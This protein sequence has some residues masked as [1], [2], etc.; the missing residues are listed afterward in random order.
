MRRLL[1]STLS[2]LLFVAC[3]RHSGNE[4]IISPTTTTIFA[5]FETPNDTRIE[6]NE[7]L[8]TVWNA[9]DRVSV[10]DS[11]AE[12]IEGRYQGESGDR[13][14]A[15]VIPN[16]LTGEAVILYPYNSG[17]KFDA[18]KQYI[19]C[20]VPN[21]QTYKRGS[22][23]VDGNMMVAS[24]STTE[25]F[26][27][28]SLYGWLRVELTGEDR[29]VE[30]ISVHSGNNESMAGAAV[31]DAQSCSIAF[32]HNMTEPENGGSVGGLLLL[33]SVTLNCAEGVELSSTP[34]HFY[35]GLV[36]QSFEKGFS[37]QVK[38][39][40][41]ENTVLSHESAITIKRNHIYP[42]KERVVLPDPVLTLS[43]EA[44]LSFSAER[45]N[46][47]ISYTLENPREG[48][49]VVASSDA[50][51]V[52]SINTLVPKKVTFIVEANTT[53]AARSANITVKYGE[54]SFTVKVKQEAGKVE[55]PNVERPERD[56]NKSYAKEHTLDYLGGAVNGKN[57]TVIIANKAVTEDFSNPFNMPNDTIC[58]ILDIYSSKSNSATLP[59]GVYRFDK[60]DTGSAG[61][62]SA[63]YS[64]YRDW[65]AG[66][67]NANGNLGF[68]GGTVTV[69]E[70]GIYIDGEFSEYKNDTEHT[71][72]YYAI[73]EGDLTLDYEE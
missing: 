19:E 6:L 66:M 33:K 29:V 64:S 24:G 21:T 7:S 69:T 27:L 9:G 41:G 23:G 58:Y 47:V 55:E 52:T 22:Y 60:D 49:K 63:T 36:P 48:L 50:S 34:T 39:R 72:Y 54:Q 68:E 5:S 70:H 38:Y 11:S 18:D 4:E 43:S 17:Y 3:S 53:T 56:P 57:Y 35:I 10:F 14:G 1:L 65:G 13:G 37:V 30:S 26:L 62:F 2:I 59:T 45:G 16:A 15:I 44:E 25:D 8:K 51:W 40:D 73:Y 31:I 42:I 61:T 71:V 12:N 46:G 28:K 67:P 20:N 32:S